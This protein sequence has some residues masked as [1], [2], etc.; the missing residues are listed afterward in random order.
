VPRRVGRRML[1]TVSTIAP[2]GYPPAGQDFIRRYRARYGD[3]TPDPYAIYGYEA[4]RVILDAVAAAGP[5][6]RAV[7]RALHRMPDRAGALGTYRFDRFGDTT[8][9]TY[10]IYRVREDELVYAGAVQAP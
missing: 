9:R 8:L 1:L 6:R 2:S 10:G 4:M 3:P 5:Q 7:I